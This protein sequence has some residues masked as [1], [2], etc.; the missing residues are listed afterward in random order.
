MRW[1]YFLTGAL[2]ASLALIAMPNSPSLW[3]AAGLLWILD[4]SVNVSM[5]PFRAFVGDM[6]PKDQR[7]RGFAMQ[8]LLI[9]LGVVL[10]SAMLF[11]LTNGFGVSKEATVDSPIP[12]A[13]K[14]AFYIGA[15]V[16]FAA[17]L[18]TILTT[19]EYPPDDMEELEAMKR[20][21]SGVG[22][23]FK[24]I[25]Q[26]TGSMPYAMLANVIPGAKMGFYMGV[27]N[28]FIVLPQILAAVALGKFVD[29]LL[30]GDAMKAVLAGEVSMAIASVATLLVGTESET[31]EIKER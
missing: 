28:F 2:L 7:K 13:V 27:F 15:G 10:S 1:P 26:G 18:V 19:K 11:I 21:R 5:E 6:L 30:G 8:S 14:L 22:H 25:F 4:A 12:P 16:F 3:V 29:S 23:A 24:E 9:G 17:V 31:G 20:D